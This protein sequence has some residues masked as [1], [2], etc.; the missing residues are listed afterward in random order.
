M[1]KLSGPPRIREYETTAGRTPYREWL[2]S[3]DVKTKARVQARVLRL[4]MGH[5]GDH[6]P[7]GHGVWEMKLDFGPGYRIYFGVS[8]KTLV[9][10]LLGGDKGS[11]RR[12]I[13]KAQE[14]W[15]DYQEVEHGSE[16]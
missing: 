13:V 2:D 4:E 6:R 12:D 11:Q 7:V 8:G 15:S 14:F 16:K 3:L 1:L 5:L 9:L 10:L